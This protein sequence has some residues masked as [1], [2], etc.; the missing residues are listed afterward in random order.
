MKLLR[1]YHMNFCIAVL[2][3]DG[4]GPE[5]I[6]EATKVLQIVCDKFGHSIQLIY[7]DIGGIAID[8][9]GTPL[10]EDT[11]DMCSKADAI[12]FGAVGGPKWD[13]PKADVRPENGILAIRKKFGLFA[14]IRPVKVY[15]DLLDASPI[16][17]QYLDGV[18]MLVVRELTGGLYFARPKKRWQTSKGRKG[19][20]TLLYTEQ[21]IVRILRMGFELALNRR[22]LLTSVDKFNVLESSRLW[23]E[24]AIELSQEYPEVTLEHILVDNASMQLIRNPSHFDVVVSE[25]TFGDILTDEASVLTGSMG[26]IPSASLSSLPL[27]QDRTTRRS[28]K[29]KQALYEPIHGA[30]PDIAGRGVANPIGAIL[31]VAMLLRYSFG[32]EL[33]ANLIEDVVTSVFSEG[34]HT[35]DIA[36]PRGILIGTSEMG[37]VI[38]NKLKHY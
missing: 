10:P 16:K 20:D 36:V 7:G 29:L 2:P 27:S 8:K 12:L 35:P 32:L 18:D 23:R 34:Y 31:S 37:D 6:S 25:N 1:S 26:M 14:N 9:S 5:V 28:T 11:I 30:A 19:V 21:E 17:P 3:G 15:P 4:V 38:S 24:I 22:K 13:D 33:E